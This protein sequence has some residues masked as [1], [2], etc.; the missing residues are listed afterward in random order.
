[1]VRGMNAHDR[2]LVLVAGGVV[3]V[4]ILA[5]VVVLV[6]GGRQPETFPADTPEGTIQRYLSAFDAGDHAAAYDFFSTEV[7]RRMSLDDY[8]LM[9]DQTG[10]DFGGAQT[11]RVLF[12]TVDVSGDTARVRLTVERIYGDGLSTSTSR[13]T[14]EIRLVREAGAWRIDEP[15]VWLDPG[16]FEPAH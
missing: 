8:T 7:R 13:S 6:A 5:I 12:D 1:M 16:Y 3:A 14:S 2:S 15:L 10:H 11:G 9:V 4:T